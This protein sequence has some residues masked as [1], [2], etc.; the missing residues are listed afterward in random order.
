[1]RRLVPEDH[2]G[3]CNQ[4]RQI[5]VSRIV[6]VVNTVLWSKYIL[7]RRQLV[8]ALRQRDHC[9]WVSDL[10]LP[11]EEFAA[12]FQEIDF[13]KGTNETLLMLG[14][15]KTNFPPIINHGFDTRCSSRAMYGSG[16]CL[17]TGTCKVLQCCDRANGSTF[18]SSDTECCFDLTNG[19]SIS[20][21]FLQAF[22]V[23]AC[24]VG[25][26]CACLLVVV[27][28]WFSIFI[29]ACH[30]KLCD[31]R[32]AVKGNVNARVVAKGETRPAKRT[33]IIACYSCL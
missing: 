24:G 19:T 11:A 10:L 9:P 20:L 12:T 33:R 30:V 4:A 17:T 14:T 13:E 31:V 32:C 23:G 25:G 26:A 29:K 8:Q 15:E 27:W 5:T 1:M 22:S 28:W 7:R 18:P 21:Y 6:S 3:T 2:Y 16:V